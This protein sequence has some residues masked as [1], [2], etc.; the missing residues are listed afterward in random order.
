MRKYYNWTIKTPTG[1]WLGHA[2]TRTNY[3]GVKW[4]L[5]KSNRKIFYATR[6][7]AYAFLLYVNTISVGEC[8]L[9]KFRKGSK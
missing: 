5:E 6:Q 9:V 4:E 3:P 8:W 2:D 7:E 1:H